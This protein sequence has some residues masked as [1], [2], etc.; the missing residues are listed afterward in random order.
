M[1]TRY[2]QATADVAMLAVLPSPSETQTKEQMDRTDSYKDD[3]E[4][5]H[6]KE[7][8]WGRYHASRHDVV[9]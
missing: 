1:P 9:C 8:E 5:G 3:D 6:S 4:R 2:D 7:N